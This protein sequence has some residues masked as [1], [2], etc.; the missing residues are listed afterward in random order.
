M[1]TNTTVLL[2]SISGGLLLATGPARADADCQ[3][4]VCCAKAAASLQT[5]RNLEQYP[6]LTRQSRPATAPAPQTRS[7]AIAM[8]PR[9][10]EVH[11]GLLRAR[12]KPEKAPAVATSNAAL[13]ASPRFL[14]N[15]PDLTRST[16]Q[17]QIAPLK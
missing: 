9:S 14:E 3:D 1:K 7:T 8:N 6:E 13:A 11:P 4:C 17:F 5:P 12:V 16:P 10:L 15:H 2:L